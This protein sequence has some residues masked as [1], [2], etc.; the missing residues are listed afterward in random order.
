MIAALVH[1]GLASDGRHETDAWIFLSADPNHGFDFHHFAMGVILEYYIT[2]AG[3]TSSDEET[4]RVHTYTDGC[5]EPYKG[6][7]N[8]EAV[9]KEARRRVKSLLTTT[10]LPLRTSRAHTTGL[11]GW[12]RTRY[13]RRTHRPGA[14]M[15][16]T[17]H[18]SFFAP[19]SRSGVR[20]KAALLRIGIRTTLR[21]TT[22]SSWVRR[23]FLVHL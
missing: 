21:A 3:G 2:G 22:S 18:T 1:H 17:L 15:T 7:R 4:P 13:A 10:L 11:V 14:S 20:R 12:Q 9:A 8:F 23:R 16:R 5:G 6:K 19:M